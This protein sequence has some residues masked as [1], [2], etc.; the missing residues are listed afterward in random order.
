MLL[1]WVFNML[2][3]NITE[4][5]IHTLDHIVFGMIQFWIKKKLERKKSYI[6]L[7]L[8]V[9]PNKIKYW[10]FLDDM[11]CLTS[12]RCDVL[13]LTFILVFLMTLCSEPSC[14]GS[15]TLRERNPIYIFIEEG[16]KW[17]FAVLLATWLCGLINTSRVGYIYID[18]DIDTLDQ[19]VFGMIHFWIKTWE[20]E[21]VFI[22][23]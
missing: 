9:R 2:G 11:C 16:T 19:V 18:F 23:P 20:K 10:C 21:I 6:Y 5:Y 4:F 12:V 22:S 3:G 13:T 15:K 1:I 14:F 7:H 8:Q 17:T